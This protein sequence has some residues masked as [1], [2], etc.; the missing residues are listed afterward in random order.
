MLTSGCASRTPVP[1]ER[2]VF[3]GVKVFHARPADRGKAI[4][5]ARELALVN[6]VIPE[7]AKVRVARV[8]SNPQGIVPFSGSLSWTGVPNQYYVTANNVFKHGLHRQTAFH[9]A[10]HALFERTRVLRSD[11]SF[12]HWRFWVHSPVSRE[13]NYRLFDESNY[14]PRSSPYWGHP[15]DSASETFASGATVMR[16][17]PKGFLREMRRL[18]RKSPET[19][20]HAL[21]VSR[22]IT[23]AFG[24]RRKEFFNPKLLAYL[25]NGR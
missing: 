23:H 5:L 24:L 10:C 9:E 21:H 3:D 16:F 22:E 6:S 11:E 4:E 25:R 7:G 12:E 18:K 2:V 1:R 19:Y 8:R 15:S 17:W 20:E 13:D 14:V